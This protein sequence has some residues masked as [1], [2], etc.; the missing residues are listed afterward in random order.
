MKKSNHIKARTLGRR[1][2]KRVLSMVKNTL[3]LEIDC[4]QC[5][6]KMEIFAEE[7][8]KGVSP[9][10]ATQLVK[11]H[12]ERCMDCREEFESLLLSLKKI[13]LS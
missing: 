10:E 3:P 7:K 12:I 11:E 4:E 2:L 9:G 8:L 1:D 5:Q 6:S 13:G